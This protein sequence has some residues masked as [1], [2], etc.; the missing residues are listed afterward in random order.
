M[1]ALRAWKALGLLAA[2]LSL[3][4]AG[5]GSSS[6]GEATPTKEPVKLFVPCDG[7]SDD[8]V[9]KA[10]ADPASEESGIAGVHQTD[11]EICSWKASGY[12]INLY[13]WPKTF[14]DL[15][16]DSR[17]RDFVETEVNGRK[18]VQFREASDTLAERCDIALSARQGSISINIQKTL[19]EPS[20][21]DPCVTANRSARTL[22]AQL[23]E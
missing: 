10:G 4:I 7:I 22:V 15:R 19:S 11:M 8:L 23:P 18:A 13:S 1:A 16:S 20:P 12:Y 3:A 14:D 2:G 21:E 6:G 9:Q 17:Y 5:C